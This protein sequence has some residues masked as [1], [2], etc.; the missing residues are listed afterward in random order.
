MIKVKKIPTINISFRLIKQLLKIGFPIMLVWLL[1]TLLRSS[2]RIVILSMISEEALGYYGVATVVAGVISIIPLTVYSVILP[3][4]MEKL[5]QTNNIN[6]IKYYLVEPAVITAFF[7]PIV[8]A[9]IYYSIHI[10][11]I[12]FLEKYFDSISVIKILSF[13][14]FFS[15]F[16]IPLSTC[17]ALNKQK[18]IAY[19][20]VPPILLNIIINYILVSLNFGLNGVAIGTGVSYFVLCSS[21]FWF[22]LKQFDDSGSEIFNFLLFLYS[23]FFYSILLIIV[24]DRYLKFDTNTF[25]SDIGS[26]FIKFGIFLIFYSFIIVLNRKHSSFKKFT[27]NFNVLNFLKNPGGISL[28]PRQTAS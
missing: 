9:S 8:I 23:P 1:L 3:R 14:L 28:M 27:D 11:I 7:L 19:L 17:V 15:S 24:L 25:W 16:A 13:A 2:D 18:A 10:P 21:V 22:S 4:I 20:L 5:G 12:Y 26:T 6:S